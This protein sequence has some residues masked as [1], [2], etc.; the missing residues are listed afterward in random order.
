MCQVNATE[1][2]G[3]EF[4]GATLYGYNSGHECKVFVSFAVWDARLQADATRIRGK[5]ARQ[6]ESKGVWGGMESAI[7]SIAGWPEWKRRFAWSD[8]FRHSVKEGEAGFTAL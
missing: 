7:L 8:E 6:G 1:I 5:I 3:C 4:C 2:T